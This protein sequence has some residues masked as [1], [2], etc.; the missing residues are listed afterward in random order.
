MHSGNA[1]GSL[2]ALWC[3][4]NQAC[5]FVSKLAYIVTQYTCKQG[6]TRNLDFFNKFIFI[7]I[8]AKYIHNRSSV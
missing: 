4:F 3:R 2:V 8:G 5:H 7:S 1:T 6:Q